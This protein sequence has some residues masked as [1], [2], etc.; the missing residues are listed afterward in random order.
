MWFWPS[1]ISS[2][3]CSHGARINW[4]SMLFSVAVLVAHLLTNMSTFHHP[5]S[6]VDYFAGPFYF[7]LEVQTSIEDSYI[8]T[9]INIAIFLILFDNV[10][11]I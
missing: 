8:Y 3:L 6:L 11:K 5:C 10:S 9:P 1:C 7:I 2:Y 4:H